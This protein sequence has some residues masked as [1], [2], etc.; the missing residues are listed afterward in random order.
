M[1]TDGDLAVPLLPYGVLRFQGLRLT[2]PLG[3][4]LLGCWAGLLL[5]CFT[6]FT[7]FCVAPAVRG[8]G[9][10][11]FVRFA[12]RKAS[13]G[14]LFGGAP[15]TAPGAAGRSGHTSADTAPPAIV[16]QQQGTRRSW[17]PKRQKTPAPRDCWICKKR[18]NMRFPE[19]TP[20]SIST[21][22]YSGKQK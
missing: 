8:A 5:N 3:S 17:G 7:H 12:T 10:R 18:E 15:C 14:Q 1:E 22:P 13:F 4:C 21:S 9:R 2:L 11:R 6:Y 19:L 16:R 20:G